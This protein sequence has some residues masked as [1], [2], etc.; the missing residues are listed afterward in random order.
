MSRNLKALGLALLAAFALSAVAASAA[1]AHTVATFTSGSD[2]TILHSKAENV[3]VFKE[4][5]IEVKCSSIAVDGSM[6]TDEASITV[7]PTYGVTTDT[8][9]AT[10]C[11]LV[12]LGSEFEAQ[13]HTNGCHYLFTAGGETDGEVHITCP[14][15][16]SIE[17]TGDILGKW[18][19][20]IDVGAQTPTTPTV[21]YTNETE[22]TGGINVWDV[23]VKSDAKKIHYT[24][25][26]LCGS[27]LFTEAEYTGAVTVWGTDTAGKAVNVTWDPTVK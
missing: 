21:T 11:K 18:R 19:P 12:A 20:C 3:Q 10:E 15:G 9:G 2:W 16:Q 27:G 8:T 5:A 24:K 22:V 4:G 26:G 13:V 23:T 7:T 25:T 6:G 14:T 17:V 1:S